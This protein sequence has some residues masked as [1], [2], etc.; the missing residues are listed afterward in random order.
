MEFFRDSVV[1][2]KI[3]ITIVLEKISFSSNPMNPNYVYTL[4]IF[5]DTNLFSVYLK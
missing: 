2:R 4:F 5:R 3:V 1:E